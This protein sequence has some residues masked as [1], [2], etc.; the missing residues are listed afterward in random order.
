M[1]MESSTVNQRLV[2]VARSLRDHHE[3]LNENTAP[4]MS[5]KDWEDFTGI[6]QTFMDGAREIGRRYKKTAPVVH[7]IEI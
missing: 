2:H 5:Q 3:R 7:E 1:D 4:M 6:V